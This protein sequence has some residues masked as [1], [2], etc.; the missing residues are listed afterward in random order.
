MKKTI[1]TIVLTVLF[2]F[3]ALVAYLAIS[4]RGQT[5]EDYQETPTPFVSPCHVWH[6]CGSTVASNAGKWKS[7][8]KEVRIYTTYIGIKE[9]YPGLTLTQ[10]RQLSNLFMS[11]INEKVGE[12]EDSL[13]ISVLMA[14]CSIELEGD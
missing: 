7:S 11:C 1:A 10:Y 6:D 5:I 4:T 2:C 9:F 13:E 14:V 12:Y 8:S 3:F